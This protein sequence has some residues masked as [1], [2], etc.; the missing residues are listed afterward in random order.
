MLISYPLYLQRLY[1]FS[2]LI[3]S[4]E[5]HSRSFD[6]INQTFVPAPILDDF[7]N[8][9]HTI[10]EDGKKV[11]PSYNGYIICVIIDQEICFPQF[12]SSSITR[13]HSR[14]R[15]PKYDHFFLI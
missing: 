11:S 15:G 8:I 1:G 3:F 5:Y 7:Q 2:G 10:F 14:G 12:K 4:S 13:H 9:V 6:W